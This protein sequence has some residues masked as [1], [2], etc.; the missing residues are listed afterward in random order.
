MAATSVLSGS[1][2]VYSRRV[3]GHRVRTYNWPPLQLN[4][5]ILIMLLAASSVVGVFATFIQIQGQLEL[6]VPWYVSLRPPPKP[7]LSLCGGKKHRRAG[8]WRA[9]KT[10]DEM[11]CGRYFP[12]YVSV[13]AV[14]ITTVLG[15]FMLIYQR[16]LLPSIVMIGAFMLFVLWMVGLI[17]TAIELFGPNGSVQSNCNLQ[18]FNQNP[19]G[20][21]METLAWMQ[22]K[23]ICK[24]PA[25]REVIGVRAHALTSY[26]LAQVSRGIWSS[27]WGWSGPSSW[28]GS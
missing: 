25:D 2:A 11:L 9:R 14:A 15:L 7:S 5:W 18:V 4:F 10:N 27:P 28:C 19:K 20:P 1:S 8:S 24:F 16:R 12:Y 13:G 23:S 6:P 26:P 3:S 21:S 22:Q 17:V